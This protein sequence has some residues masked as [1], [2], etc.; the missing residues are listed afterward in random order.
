[1]I[2]LGG[3]PEILAALRAGAVNAGIL[4][5]PTSTAA[6]DLGFR[7]LLHI[8]DLGKEFTFSGIAARRTFVQSQPEIARSYMAALTDGAKVYKEDSRAALRV[9]RKYMRAEDR[10][11]ENGYKEYDKAISSPPYPAI[12]GLEAVRESLL[13][14]T[15][16]LKNVDLR[17]FIDDRF[18]K[19]K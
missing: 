4:S 5:P 11:L 19:A 2:S 6:R 8:P 7:P 15:P 10:I 16:Q 18:V 17:K 1:M 9:L 14:S 3:I 12:K 13:D